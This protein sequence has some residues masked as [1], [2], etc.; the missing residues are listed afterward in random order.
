MKHI[1]LIAWLFFIFLMAYSN[2]F[3]LF[4]IGICVVSF[5]VSW[6]LAEWQHKNGTFNPPADNTPV[7]KTT[8]SRRRR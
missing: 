7:R 1:G 3:F 2:E 8:R 4:L 6:K 5:V